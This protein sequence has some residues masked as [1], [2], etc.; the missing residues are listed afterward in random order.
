[1][2]G[3]WRDGSFI[4]DSTLETRE[5]KLIADNARLRTLETLT[6]KYCE[7]LD[8]GYDVLAEDALDQVR[9]WLSRPA[10]TK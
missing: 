9:E 4:L 3:V 5:R 2:N 7:D 6:R 8:D 1:M 10:V